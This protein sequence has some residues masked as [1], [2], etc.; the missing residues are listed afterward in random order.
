MHTLRAYATATTRQR[1]NKHMAANINGT[2]KDKNT[3]LTVYILQKF[4]KY[5][6]NLS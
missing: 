5:K 1:V 3:K 4:K 2:K 6:K